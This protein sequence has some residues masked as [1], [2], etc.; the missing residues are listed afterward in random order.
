M[1]KATISNID[2]YDQVSL[3]AQL[4]IDIFNKMN[5]CETYLHKH[6]LKIGEIVFMQNIHKKDTVMVVHF[7]ENTLVQLPQYKCYFLNSGVVRLRKGVLNLRDYGVKEN[8]LLVEFLSFEFDF[9]SLSP[10]SINSFINQIKSSKKDSSY[11]PLNDNCYHSFIDGSTSQCAFWEEIEIGIIRCTYDTNVIEN[12]HLLDQIKCC[13]I[14]PTKVR[15]KIAIVG[16]RGFKNKKSL[17]KTMN[18]LQEK[19][20][21]TDIVSGGAKGADTLGVQWANKE[22]IN[23]I[24]YLPEFKKHKRAY[25]FRNRQIVVEAD[26][27]VA[28]WDGSSTGTKYTM[29]FT[30]TEEKELI[31]VKF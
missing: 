18:E 9:R 12:T 22:K 5:I 30:K 17:A 31:V 24:V 15:K 14:V 29:N 19:Y 21:I 16:S 27:V 23:T 1:K 26:I 11:I 8:Q 7:D 2:K 20:I 6:N 4:L 25:H 28:F 3:M 13:N 10:K